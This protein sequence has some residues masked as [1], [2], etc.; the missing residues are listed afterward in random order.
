[1]AKQTPHGPIDSALAALHEA[2]S[3]PSRIPQIKAQLSYV[4]PQI[5]NRAH[6]TY[7]EEKLNEIEDA[8]NSPRDLDAIAHQIDI[9]NDREFPLSR[10]YRSK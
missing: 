1:M 8:R 10:G 5:L 9:W 3:R 4:F 6:R 7:L 2:A